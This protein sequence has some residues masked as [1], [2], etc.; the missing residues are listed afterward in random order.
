MNVQEFL[1][2]VT[3]LLDMSE[4]V[5]L[6]QDL[7]EIPT[8]DSLGILN[9]LALYDSMGVSASPEGLSEAKTTNDLVAIAADKL[10][11]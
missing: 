8:Y 9:L 5:V 7:S 6:G 2:Q 10:E 1:D 3:E 4:P 11:R